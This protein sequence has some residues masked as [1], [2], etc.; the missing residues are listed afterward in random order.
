VP[1]ALKPKK[2][3]PTFYECF[4]GLYFGCYVKET[5]PFVNILD[6]GTWPSILILEKLWMYV[7]QTM[8]SMYLG[9]SEGYV[10]WLLKHWNGHE[11][12][13]LVLWWKL[14]PYPYIDSLISIGGINGTDEIYNHLSSRGKWVILYVSVSQNY[15]NVVNMAQKRLAFMANGIHKIQIF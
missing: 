10:M 2:G 5:W 12:I 13:V 14:C 11:V 1:R 3:L 4:E 15:R 6:V 7:E 8:M 9:G